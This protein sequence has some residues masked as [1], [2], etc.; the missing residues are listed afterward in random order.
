MDRKRAR[1][2]AGCAPGRGLTAD[3]RLMFVIASPDRN[4]VERCPRAPPKPVELLPL[5]GSSTARVLAGGCR[6]QWFSASV[7]A[8]WPPS[9]S[10]STGTR[11]WSC[12]A[13]GNAVKRRCC[14]SW[15]QRSCGTKSA[16]VQLEIVDYR[17]TL[18]GDVESDHLGG[19]SVSPGA[20]TARMAT[21]TAALSATHARRPHQS[22]STPG[23]V[24][25]AG[26][27]IYVLV[28]DYDLVAGAT[29]NPLT[30]LADFLPHA[31]DLGLHVIVAR[32][33]GGAARAMFD[34]V[35]A[36][37]RDMGCAGLMMSASP[38]EGVLLGGVRP[39][40]MP[41]GRGLL[42]RRGEPDELVQ[43]G[44]VEPP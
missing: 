16:E 29:G 6:G 14:V 11:I 41:A 5:P 40:A 37:M 44:W 23:P 1:E 21:L 18:L 4:L 24:M 26:P 19:Y 17:R 42:L 28:D 25:V 12:S 10:I 22:A 43:I 31:G 30:P 13:K 7:N 20:L 33:S 34:P 35:L 2:L 9:P 38:D 39:T 27:D 3:G 8:N 32:R 15:A 36:R